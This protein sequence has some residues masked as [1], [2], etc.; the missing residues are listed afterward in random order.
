MWD[1]PVDPQLVL[2]RTKTQVRSIA[3]EMLQHKLFETVRAGAL[4]AYCFERLVLGH[5]A[6]NDAHLNLHGVQNAAHLL[7][8]VLWAGTMQPLLALP[9]ATADGFLRSKR[10]LVTQFQQ[11]RG[12]DHDHVSLIP[13][14]E[15]T[16]VQRR[17][18]QDN[19]PEAT[20]GNLDATCQR[21]RSGHSQILKYPGY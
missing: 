20:G 6:G 14:P 15:P 3:C 5:C 4:P 2:W 21:T 17:R 11:I 16:R 10:R 13:Q 18:R 8:F 19:G 1:G 9:P 12:A 7:G